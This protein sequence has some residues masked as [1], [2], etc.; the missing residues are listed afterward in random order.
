[1]PAD[2]LALVSGVNGGVEHEGVNAAVPGHVYEAHKGFVLVGAD[3]CQAV[4]EDKRE[5]SPAMIRP[6]RGEEVIEF[7]VGDRRADAVGE[8]GR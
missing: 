1:M 8:G 2:A 5:V 7:L 6:S 3:V 4:G